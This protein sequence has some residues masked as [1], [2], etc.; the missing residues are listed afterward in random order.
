MAKYTDEQKKAV[1][2]RIPEIGVREA[3]AEAGIPWKTVAKWNRDAANAEASKKVAEAEENL[4]EA[5]KKYNEA[6]AIADKATKENA[7]AVKEA[8][9][10]INKNI[11]KN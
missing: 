11:I 7:K 5:E 6:D 8:V 2:D 4:K 3:A 10:L 9:G 1:L